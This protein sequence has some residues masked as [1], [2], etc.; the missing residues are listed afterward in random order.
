MITTKQ[1]QVWIYLLA[2]YVLVPPCETPT[3]DQR[4]AVGAKHVF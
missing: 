4:N 3:E 1:N 2:L